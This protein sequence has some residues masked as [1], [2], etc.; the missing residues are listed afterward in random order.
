M[1]LSFEVMKTK[2][3]LIYWSKGNL[4]YWSRWWG[5]LIYWNKRWGS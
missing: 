4:I 5:G 3:D 1:L 2:I